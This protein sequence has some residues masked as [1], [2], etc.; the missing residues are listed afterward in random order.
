M[1]D[2][3]PLLDGLRWPPERPR[4]EVDDNPWAFLPAV[5]RT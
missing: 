3:P 1:A 5:S 4:S 2:Q